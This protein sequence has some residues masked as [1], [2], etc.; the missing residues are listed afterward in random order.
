MKTYRQCPECKKNTIN[1]AELKKGT[2]CS[3]CGAAVL[4]G[5]LHSGLVSI[6]LALM[7]S[8]LVERDF[9]GLAI[10]VLFML[11]LRAFFLEE[12]DARFLPISKI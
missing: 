11:A 7:I 2:F 12:F 1:I 6:S 4:I 9:L 5:A 10:V 3:S 8:I